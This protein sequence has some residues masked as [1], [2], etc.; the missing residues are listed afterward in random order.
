MVK[1]VTKVII[2]MNTLKCC[3]LLRLSKKK[4]NVM[5]IQL[6]NFYIMKECQTFGFK[7]LE[8]ITIHSRYIFNEDE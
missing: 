8:K 5:D 3:Y 1:V 4:D 7:Q 2:R 6:F